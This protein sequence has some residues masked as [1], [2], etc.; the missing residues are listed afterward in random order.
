MSIVDI[1]SKPWPW[2][3]AGPMISFVMFLLLWFGKSF[4]ISSSLRNVCSIAGAGKYYKYF[5]YY[6]STNSFTN[7]EQG[8]FYFF[9]VYLFSCMFKYFLNFLSIS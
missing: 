1:I 5:E 2:Y 9:I 8:N 7:L 4:G 3:V 6:S